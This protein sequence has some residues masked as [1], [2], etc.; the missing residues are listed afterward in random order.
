MFYLNVW[1]TVT[2]EARIG[3]VRDA[4]ARTGRASAAEAGC[5]RWEA[6]QSEEDP[7]R[8][9]LVERWTT[10]AHWEDHRQGAAIQEIYMKEVIPYVQREPH[11]SSLIYSV[12]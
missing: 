10:K 11:P 9:L 8:F 7:K 2:D 3:S 5:E 1:L 4:L 12:K 6:Y